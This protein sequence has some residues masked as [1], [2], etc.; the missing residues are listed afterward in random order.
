MTR[1]VLLGGGY[2]T[3][4][5]YAGL[6]RRRAR[7]LR[8][9]D[10]EMV[11]ISADHAHRFHGFTGELMAGMV[12]RDRL[13]TPLAEAMPRARIILGRAVGIDAQGRSVSFRRDD[14]AAV[15][16]LTYDHLVVGT[17]ATEPV[18]GIA[19]L[20]RHGFTLRGPDEIAALADHLSAAPGSAAVVAGGGIAGAELA[21]AIADR[22]HPV[23]LVHGGARILAEWMNHPG[24][25]ERAEAELRRLG[26][27]VLP[28]TR[29]VE[30]TSTEA[31]LSDGRAI[32]AA[33]V[34][35]ATGQRPVQIPGVDQWRDDLGRLRTRR[36]L[37]V[38]RG[39]WAAGDGAR[40][41]HPVVG[42]PVPANA[43][44]AMK[45]GDHIGRAIA[46]EL[47]GRTAKPFRYPGL[48]RAASFGFGRGIS[49]LYGVPFRGAPA[50]MLRL[51]FFLRFMPSRARAAG[52]VADLTR[53]AFRG[54][55]G[56]L[57]ERSRAQSS[58]LTPE[59][60]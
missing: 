13:A 33:T 37:A 59:H 56:N 27:T 9:G 15:E 47:E 60:A 11:V 19:G 17:G 10:L 52:V 16:T 39:L 44:W 12:A 55:A 58:T 1:V 48:G 7:D 2:V 6:A 28:H 54:P 29:V 43:L 41:T 57:A 31:V 25:V 32:P 42:G 14:G 30:V 45:G 24:L 38:T 36:T 51:V 50:W 35:A 40:V 21:A 49:E 34:V 26:V 53:Y 5:A 18:A 22:G 23:T 46:R 20:P 4:H 8:R 3:L